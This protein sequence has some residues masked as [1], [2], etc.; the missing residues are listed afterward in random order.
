MENMYRMGRLNELNDNPETFFEQ[1][2]T[3]KA[4][5]GNIMELCK[6]IFSKDTAQDLFRDVGKQQQKGKELS[7]DILQFEQKNYKRYLKLKAKTKECTQMF[8]K[9]KLFE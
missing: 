6:S 8:N 1:H 9:I 2:N 5:G 7:R 3:R 4:E